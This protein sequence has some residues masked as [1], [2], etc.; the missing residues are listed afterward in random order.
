MVA[1]VAAGWGSRGLRSRPLP[2]HGGGLELGDF[3]LGVG[4]LGGHSLHSRGDFRGVLGVPVGLV[5]GCDT[6]DGV[7]AVE[8]QGAALWFVR[9]AALVEL[10]LAVPHR[11]HS[12]FTV[13]VRA[14]GA[15]LDCAL[16]PEVGG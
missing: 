1:L 4:R 12:H 7:G 5:V 9:S 2:Y 16:A 10:S 11:P 13:W 15:V 8:I 14:L 6:S 3:L